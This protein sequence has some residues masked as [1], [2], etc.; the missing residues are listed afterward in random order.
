MSKCDIFVELDEPNRRYGA[1][2]TVRGKVRVVVDDACKC[3]AL[4]IE[5]RW[6]THGRGNQTGVIRERDIPFQGK[7]S[8]GA[9]HVYPFELA[10]P[11]GPHSYHGHYLNVDWYVRATADI[12][13]AVDPKAELDLLVGPGPQTDPDTYANTDQAHGGLS[14]ARAESD[15]SASTHFW[16]LFSLP[17]IGMG[18]FFTF[19]TFSGDATGE[20]DFMGGI[21]GLGCTAAGLSLAYLAVRNSLAQR[22]LGHVVMVWPRE[23]LEP[24]RQLPLELRINASARDRLNAVKATLICRERVVSGSG[25]NR[26]THTEEV[27]RETAVFEEVADADAAGPGR[28]AMR[29]TPRLPDGAPPSFYAD[30]NEL[31][32]LLD[33]HVDVEKWP[34]WQREFVLD[35]RPAPG[36]DALPG[37]G[38]DKPA[39]E[40][41]SDEPELEAGVVW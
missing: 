17:F 1:G 16:L 20:T 39:S 8:A 18:L 24:G 25:T 13:W 14:K 29:A 11:N 37:A 15:A 36:A 28:L 6:Q 12:P 19:R 31:I 23:V 9:E 5:L 27:F 32:W 10:V 40:A 34:D 22:K 30:D 41:R 33:I 7:W 26:T 4:K 38:P 3:D 35:V 21:L 2:D